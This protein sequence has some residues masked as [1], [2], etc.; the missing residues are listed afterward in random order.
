MSTSNPRTYP[1]LCPKCKKAVE[2][3]IP[4]DGQING[5]MR[6]VCDHCGVDQVLDAYCNALAKQAR[7]EYNETVRRK[8]KLARA[9]ETEEES[10]PG[11]IGR[12][13]DEYATK[14]KQ[15]WPKEPKE[16]RYDLE[17]ELE[18]CRRARRPG[19]AHRFASLLGIGLLLVFSLSLFLGGVFGPNGQPMYAGALLFGL[20]IVAFKVFDATL[21][22]MAIRTDLYEYHRRQA[23]SD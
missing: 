8:K 22:L 2:I 6:V 14:H 15:H 7:K 3:E 23:G 1:G 11:H 21:V 17:K 9:N 16:H 10:I 19:S 5:K 13:L 20:A 12:R 18:K 4:E